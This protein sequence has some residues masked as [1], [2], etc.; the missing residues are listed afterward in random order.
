MSTASLQLIQGDPA[1]WGVPAEGKTFV[2]ID[3]SGLLTLKQNDGS[4]ITLATN[5]PGFSS[6]VNSSGTTT[7]SPTTPV[8]RQIVDIQNSPRDV[9]IVLDVDGMVEGSVINLLIKMPD[10]AGFI[11][12]VYNASGSGTLLAQVANAGDPVIVTAQY[13]FVFTS[14]AWV[15]FSALVPAY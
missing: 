7:I 15:L 2:G 11:A 4:I 9:P 12:K 5:V 10:T 14:G 13:S 6:V 3:E 1:T 8:W